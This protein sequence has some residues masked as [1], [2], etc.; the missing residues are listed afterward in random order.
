[1]IC[2]YNINTG[3]IMAYCTPGQ[4]YQAVL[5]NFEDVSWVY[6]DNPIPPFNQAGQWFIDLE[7]KK[8]YR[9]YQ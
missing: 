6:S 5:N 9:K 3:L 8:M 4:N 2:I 1:M 7:T